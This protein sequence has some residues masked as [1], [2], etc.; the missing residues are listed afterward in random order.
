MSDTTGSQTVRS[1]KGSVMVEPGDVEVERG[2]S[3]IVSAKFTSNKSDVKL[4]V[5]EHG[6][7]QRWMTMVQSLDDPTYSYRLANVQSNAVYSVVSGGQQS[8]LYRMTVFEYPELKSSQA[9]L[10]YP[11]SVSYTHLTLP[12]ILLV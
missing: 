4:V 7:D 10:D 9:R 6:R 5:K 3:L 2:T 11:E 8:D 12:T 1:A